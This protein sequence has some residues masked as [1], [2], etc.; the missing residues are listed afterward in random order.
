MGRK[1]ADATKACRI[2]RTRGEIVRDR[3]LVTACWC[4]AP[5]AGFLLVVFLGE[6]FLGATLFGSLDL[7]PLEAACGVLALGGDASAC[8]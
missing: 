6:T 8:P 3:R 7:L 2:R 1:L 4:A 5:A